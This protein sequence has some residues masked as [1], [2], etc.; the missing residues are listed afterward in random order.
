MK[1]MSFLLFALC[2]SVAAFAQTWN[3][4]KAHAKV[5]FTVTHLAIS[6]VDGSFKKFDAKITSSKEDFSDAVFE[7]SADIKSVSTD[8]DGR[9]GHLQKPDMFDS[10]KFPTLTFKSTGITK[11]A[12]KKY[13]LTGDLTIKGVTKSVTLDLLHMGSTVNQRSG[14]KIAGFKAS[15]YVKRTD[16]GVGNMPS[17]MVSEDIELRASGEFV[18]Q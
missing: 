18:A 12:D 13:K 11:V 4:D 10:E 17:M 1:K 6:E 9:D 14:K 15:G 16:F 8:N 7:F 2:T 5:G 3:V